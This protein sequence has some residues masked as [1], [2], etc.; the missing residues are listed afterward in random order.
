LCGEIKVPRPDAEPFD[1]QPQVLVADWILCRSLNC[2][3]HA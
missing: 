1:S 2:A 3:G